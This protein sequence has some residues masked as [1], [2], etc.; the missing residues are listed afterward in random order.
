MGKIYED[1]EI[2]VDVTFFESDVATTP[3][4]TVSF[5]Y[6]ITTEGE[7]VTVPS[8]SIVNIG[9][10]Q[11]RATFTPGSP[12]ML[13]GTWTSSAE[14][15]LTKPVRIPIFPKTGFWAA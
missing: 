9:T 6:K 1:T 4:G 8:S 12:G 5:V 10:G 3:T 13:Y 7:E 14:P 2:E 15:K 11:Y